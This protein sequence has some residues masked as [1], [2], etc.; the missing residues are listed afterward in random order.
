VKLFSRSDFFLFLKYLFG[1]LLL[2]LPL[3]IFI[4][5]GRALLAQASWFL[6]ENFSKAFKLTT[7]RQTGQT[8]FN[9][10]TA[11]GTESYLWIPKINAKAKIVFPVIKDSKELLKWLEKGVIHYPESA[12]FGKNGVAVLLG[13]SSAYPWYKGEYGSVFALLEKLKPDD[14][15]IVVSSGKKYLYRVSGL[16]VVVPKDFKVENPDGRSHLWLMSC[17]PVRT[18]KLRMVVVSDLIREE[19]L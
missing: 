15:V 4:F 5:N 6:R 12:D 3:V 19:S 18:N 11:S 17:W 16:K 8:N 1:Y 9:Q 2:L 13:H 7:D 14:E 10:I